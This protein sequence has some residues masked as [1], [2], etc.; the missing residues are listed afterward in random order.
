MGIGGIIGW[1]FS[2]LTGNILLTWLYNSTRGSILITALF[3][4]TIDIAF[5]SDIVNTNIMNYIGMLITIFAVAVLI[6][7]KPK[8]LSKI[9]RQ[10]IN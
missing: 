2:L 10:V 3:H 8:N 7:F 6:I 9:E 1:I 5:T 4:A